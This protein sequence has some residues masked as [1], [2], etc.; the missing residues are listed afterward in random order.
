MNSTDRKARVKRAEA[1]CARVGGRV[2]SGK[3]RNVIIIELPIDPAART[4]PLWGDAGFHPPIFIREEFRSGAA[5]VLYDLDLRP[6]ANGMSRS[7]NI[8]DIAHRVR[9]SHNVFRKKRRE[10]P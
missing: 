5:R 3:R 4:T 8:I 6:R 2:I 1:I 10:N 7:A 9:N